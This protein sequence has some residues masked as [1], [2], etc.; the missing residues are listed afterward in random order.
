MLHLL[1]PTVHRQEDGCNEHNLL[2]TRLFKMTHIKH[3][4]P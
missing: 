3:T 1:N 2:P 4:V